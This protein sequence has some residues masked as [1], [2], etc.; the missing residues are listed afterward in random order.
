MARPHYVVI[1]E[2]EI[3]LITRKVEN[4]TFHIQNTVVHNFYYRPLV[5]ARFQK[6]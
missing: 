6:L 1:A 2:K 4:L 5:I 3:V